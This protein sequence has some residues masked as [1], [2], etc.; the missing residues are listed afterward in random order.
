MSTCTRF[1]NDEIA[2]SVDGRGESLT[3]H[4]STLP[5]A[6]LLA[7]VVGPSILICRP[8]LF[9]P[10]SSRSISPFSPP[11][12]HFVMARN[13]FA[14]G[15]LFPREITTDYTRGNATGS[16]TPTEAAATTTTTA[17]AKEPV[18]AII[19]HYRRTRKIVHKK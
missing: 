15:Q 10:P 19:N 9:T 16:V 18:N 2:Y 7:L 12:L 5:P 11:S 8:A 1:S 6:A 3:W 17:A 4:V 14:V 13:Q